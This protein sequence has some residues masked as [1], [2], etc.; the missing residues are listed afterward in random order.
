MK[1]SNLHCKS[2]Y[3]TFVDFILVFF[4]KS[5]ND[6]IAWKDIFSQLEQAIIFDDQINRMI[7]DFF[8]SSQ[9]LLEVPI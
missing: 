4:T 9:V 2:S 8:K 3:L 7:C 6:Y 1:G 5:K